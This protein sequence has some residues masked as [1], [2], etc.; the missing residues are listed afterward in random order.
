MPHRK[1]SRRKTSLRKTFHRKSYR[2]SSMTKNT[3][4]QIPKQKTHTM[5]G[6]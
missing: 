2:T 1:I 6:G 5:R 3:R 4:K